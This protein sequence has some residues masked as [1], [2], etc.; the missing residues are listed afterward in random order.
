MVSLFW[1]EETV[2]VVC[3]EDNL[4]LLY[5]LALNSKSSVAICSSQHVPH[6]TPGSGKL[7]RLVRSESSEV[8]ELRD[9]MKTLDAIFW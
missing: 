7:S 2:F 5:L 9:K 1:S 8:S 4:L 6:V 3:T